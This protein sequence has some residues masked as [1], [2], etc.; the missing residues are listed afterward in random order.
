[1]NICIR[2]TRKTYRENAEKLHRNVPNI[3]VYAALELCYIFNCTA[4]FMKADL[5]M[6]LGDDITKVA[7]AFG[8]ISA[9]AGFYLL[10]HGLC[11][12]TFPFEIPLFETK[13][14]FR[15]RRFGCEGMDGASSV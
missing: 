10:A 9:T 7:G 4:H 2:Y 15:R 1:V 5:R 13:C 14:F 8:F 3:I 6:E 12:D 11:Q